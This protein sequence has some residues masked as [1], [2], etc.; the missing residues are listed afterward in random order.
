MRQLLLWLLLAASSLT[1][2]GCE[3]KRSGGDA[4]NP[5]FPPG[6]TIAEIIHGIALW[7]S[8]VGAASLLS[9]LIVGIFVS[10]QRGFQLAVAGASLLVGAQVLAWFGA[11]LFLVSVLVVLCGLL[12][13][14]IWAY[15]T[16]AAEPLIGRDL[17]RDGVI[18]RKP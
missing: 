7:G 12:A 16:G 5:D 3:K 11:H 18:G 10:R 1:L 9:A 15:R 14:G 4:P 17:N 13:A 6:V 8:V 2:I